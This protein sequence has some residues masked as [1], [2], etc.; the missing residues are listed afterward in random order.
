MDNSKTESQPPKEV[1]AQGS[2]QAP[3]AEGKKSMKEMSKAERRE[4]QVIY[5]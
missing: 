1:Q 5:S 4:L 3:P 2:A